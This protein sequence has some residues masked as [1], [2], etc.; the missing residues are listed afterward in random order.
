MIIPNIWKNN[1]DVPNHRPDW[2]SPHILINML[3][4][5]A[6]PQ[7]HPP[8][9]PPGFPPWHSLLGSMVSSSFCSASW[10]QYISPPRSPPQLRLSE[11]SSSC[12]T[13]LQV[14]LP[15]SGSTEV[16]SIPTSNW[17]AHGLDHIFLRCIPCI[18]TSSIYLYV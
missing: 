9:P 1:P 8:P 14:F 12:Q 7:A 4:P 10:L 13:D 18:V 16:P 6:V 3:V 17:L 11:V 15:V 2:Y 5:L